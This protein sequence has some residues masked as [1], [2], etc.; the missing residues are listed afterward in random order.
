MSLRQGEIAP[1]FSLP[2]VSGG[3]YT[4]AEKTKQGSYVHLVFFRHLG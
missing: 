3:T 4:L 2:A 1:D